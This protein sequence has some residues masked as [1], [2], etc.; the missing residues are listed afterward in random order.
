M[1]LSENTILYGGGPL[2]STN[3]LVTDLLFR[4]ILLVNPADLV[5]VKSMFCR[6]SIVNVVAPFPLA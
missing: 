4:Q 3:L 5:F 2:V 1:K 6:T